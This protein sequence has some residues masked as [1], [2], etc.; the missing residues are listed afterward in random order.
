MKL[1]N[2]GTIIYD[3]FA[4]DRLPCTVSKETWEQGNLTDENAKQLQIFGHQQWEEHK[5]VNSFPWNLQMAKSFIDIL[6]G[7]NAGPPT[8]L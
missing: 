2:D 6:V 1:E 5:P 7:T 8:Y 3:D 4:V